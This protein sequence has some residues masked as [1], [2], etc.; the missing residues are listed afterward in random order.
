M[1]NLLFALL[2]NLYLI[3]VLLFIVIQFNNYQ[4]LIIPGF[5]IIFATVLAFINI[6]YPILNAKKIFIDKPKQNSIN[7]MVLKF[8]L[9]A[10]PFYALN[11]LL[12]T[13]LTGLFIVMPGN[14]FFLLFVLPLGIGF[15]FLVLIA[16]S[17]YSIVLLFALRKNRKISLKQFIIHL[18][19]Q[20]IFVVDVIDQILILKLTK[21]HKE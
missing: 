10:I 14:I 7:H 2:I 1:K 8:K 12:W 18:L 21:I 9:L 20:L 13:S 4:L 15:A 11:F 6:G 19:C 16:S 3:Q 5:F 17:T